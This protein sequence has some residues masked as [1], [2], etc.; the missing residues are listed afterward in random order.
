MIE[1]SEVFKDRQENKLSNEKR[2]AWTFCKAGWYMV[3]YLVI[4]IGDTLAEIPPKSAI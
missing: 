1:D 4:L 3:R 2:N